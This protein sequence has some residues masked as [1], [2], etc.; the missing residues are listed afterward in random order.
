MTPQQLAMCRR[1]MQ[2]VAGAARPSHWQQQVFEAAL[3]LQPEVLV[4]VELEGVSTD[5]LLSIDIKADAVVA[6]AP[7]YGIDRQQQPRLT[8]LLAIEVDG[9]WHFR[10]P[11]RAVVG[12]TRFKNRLLARQGY[13]VVSIPYFQW[14]VG[15]QQQQQQ[16]AYLRAAVQ[17]ALRQQ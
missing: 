12:P 17:Q 5:G 1:G 8:R 15:A 3:Q 13:L 16:V 10:R 4:G 7:A 9:P 11:D 2:S 6:A 14:P